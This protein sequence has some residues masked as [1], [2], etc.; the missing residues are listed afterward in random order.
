M[1]CSIILFKFIFQIQSIEFCI[2]FTA[3]N[4]E[5]WD[6]NDGKNYVLISPKTALQQQSPTVSSHVRRNSDG[7]DAY[8]LNYDSWSRFAS[9]RDLST[10]GPYW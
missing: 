3:D 5:Y 6:S 8:K 2:C 1:D 7:D 10:E 4:V 9:W